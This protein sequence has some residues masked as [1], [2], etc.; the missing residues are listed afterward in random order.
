M[1]DIYHLSEFAIAQIN[2]IKLK[3]SFEDSNFQYHLEG[4]GWQA[5]AIQ[6][7]NTVFFITV[8]FR[9]GCEIHSK[10]TY[11]RYNDDIDLTEFMFAI[12][13]TFEQRGI[14]GKRKL[15]FI[16]N[17][18]PFTIEWYKRKLEFALHFVE[19]EFPEVFTLGDLTRFESDKR[20]NG[21]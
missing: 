3:Y 20:R 4:H 11:W 15:D 17:T 6:K 21:L 5:F 8:N 14:Y 2:R 10:K 16:G 13:E 12:Y 9:Q 19:S 18:E 7:N 1:I